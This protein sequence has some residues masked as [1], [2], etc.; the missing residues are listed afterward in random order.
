MGGGS[1][2]QGY[3]PGYMGKG[4]GIDAAYMAVLNQ[5]AMQMNMMKGKGKG[6]GY[7]FKGKDPEGFHTCQ[8]REEKGDG[9]TE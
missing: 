7:G 6:K 9:T 2:G 1:Q 8:A 5:M 4:Y 3:L